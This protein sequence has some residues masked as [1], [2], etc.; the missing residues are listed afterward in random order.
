MKFDIEKIEALIKVFED[1][2]LT[3]ITI[4]EG[5]NSIC[6]NRQQNIQV[7]TAP[8]GYAPVAQPATPVAPVQAT[9]EVV[10]PAEVKGHKVLSPM[11]GTFYR[12]SSPDAQPFVEIGTR[13]KVGDPLCIVEAMKMMNRIEADKEGVITAI[14]VEDA[15]VVEYD[16]PLFVIE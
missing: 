12:R 11:V 1:S 2:S 14:L 13:V 5:E 8:Q 7:T 9:P 3:E 4:V 10:A 6:L 16:Q 15:N